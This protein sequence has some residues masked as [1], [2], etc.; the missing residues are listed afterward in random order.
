MPTPLFRRPPALH[1]NA[2]T[3]LSP[4]PSS[5]FFLPGYACVGVTDEVLLS[6][7]LLFSFSLLLG[8]QLLC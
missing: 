7:I 4:P 1:Q 6:G 2:R 8:Q 3:L 5:C